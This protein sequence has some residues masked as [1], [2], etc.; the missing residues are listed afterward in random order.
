MNEKNRKIANIKEMVKPGNTCGT[1][2]ECKKM[3]TLNL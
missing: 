2:R 1:Y 3:W